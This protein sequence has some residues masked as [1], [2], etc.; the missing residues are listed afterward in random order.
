MLGISRRIQG[1]HIHILFLNS[2]PRTAGI[3]AGRGRKRV[4]YDLFILYSIVIWQTK[5]CHFIQ[6]NPNLKL[7]ACAVNG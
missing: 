4:R 3:H 6:I 7:E 2:K 5:M 1:E